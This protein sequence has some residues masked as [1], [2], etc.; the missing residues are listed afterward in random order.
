MSG[1]IIKEMIEYENNQFWYIKN[2]D[3]IVK[4]YSEKYIAIYDNKIIGS[5]ENVK[6]LKDDITSE[7]SSELLCVYFDYVYKS[8]PNFVL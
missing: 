6:D 8:H 7:Y 2:Y 5:A 3:D 4:K 1:N